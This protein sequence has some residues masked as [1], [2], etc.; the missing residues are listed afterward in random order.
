M[1]IKVNYDFLRLPHLG[2]LASVISNIWG[3]TP[4]FPFTL[5]SSLDNVISVYPSFSSGDPTVIILSYHFNE[6]FGSLDYLSDNKK[7]LF[8]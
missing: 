4:L 7:L 8:D 1:F 6:L 3:H 2:L 5:I